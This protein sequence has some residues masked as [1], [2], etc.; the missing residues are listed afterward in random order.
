MPSKIN[1]ASRRLFIAAL[2]ACTVSALTRAQTARADDDEVVRVETEL[3]ILHVRVVDGANRPVRDASREEF[4]VFDNDA[5]QTVSLFTRE[6]VPVTYG[7]VVGNTGSLQPQIGPVIGLGK[8]LVESNQPADETF[9]ARFE[10]GA[11]AV[12]R[13]DFTPDRETLTRALDALRTEGGAAALLDAVYLSAEHVADSDGP[14]E[15]PDPLRR[16]AMV[17][18]TDGIDR[19]SRYKPEEVFERLRERGVQLYVIGF[20]DKLGAEKSEA[21]A[22]VRRLAE[23]SG[24][25]AFFPAAFAELP[26]VA[27]EITRD[28]RTQYVIGYRPSN[29]KHDGSYHRVRVEVADAPGRGPRTAVTRPG[30]KAPDE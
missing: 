20:V 25:R 29:N 9:L 21:V 13:W 15:T 3:V 24:G 19:G 11:R 12:I 4:R 22:L 5:P 28:L 14:S 30:Y 26:E 23:V 6:E 27:R 7:L 8:T 18:L 1:R 2:L 16:R 10:R 17:L